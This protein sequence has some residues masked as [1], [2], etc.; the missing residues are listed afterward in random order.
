MKRNYFGSE[1]KFLNIGISIF[2]FGLL[3]ARLKYLRLKNKLLKYS[4]NDII[5]KNDQSTIADFNKYLDQGYDK[6]NIGGGSYNLSGFI[7]LDFVK[8]PNIDRQVTA[9]ITDLEFI[10]NNSIS[11]IYSNQLMEHLTADELVY[12][13]TQ[14][15]RI[16]KKDGI[17]SFRT[18]NALG[19]SYGFWFGPVPETEHKEFIRL[20]YPSDA[21]FYDS[22]DGWYHKDF[23]GFLHWIYAD[24]GNIKNQHLSIF[25]PTYVA[26]LLNENGFDILK[27]TKP[28]TSQ[29]IVIA[30]PT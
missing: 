15:K 29:I 7:N 30:R 17:I 16:L 14:Y 25:T 18:P 27:I 21:F 23:F 4:R 8:F 26:G 5:L 6:I 3:K 22:R 13:F 20:G 28:E 11:H 19:V 10:P 1:L 9:N 12:Q 2:I 24:V